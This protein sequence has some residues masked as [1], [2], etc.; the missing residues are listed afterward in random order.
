MASSTLNKSHLKFTSA[1]GHAGQLSF[2]DSGFAVNKSLTLHSD[3]TSNLEA[4]TKEYVDA[5]V[6]GLSVKQPVRVATVTGVQYSYMS[7][8]TH[9]KEI[10]GIIVETGDRLLI[11]EGDGLDPGV[12]EIQASGPPKKLITSGGFTVEMIA[13]G[14]Y[15]YIEEGTVNGGTAYVVVTTN[16]TTQNPAVW[17]IFSRRDTP[18]LV[19]NLLDGSTAGSVVNSKAVIYGSSGEVHAKTLKIDGTPI[20]AT[21]SELNIL[22][23]VTATAE[24]L[25][26]V[27]GSTAGSVVNSKAVIYGSSGEVHAKTLKIDGTPINATAS[28]LNILHG[29]TVTAADLNRLD[30]A[31]AG[32]HT[33][34]KAAIYGEHG[35]LTAHEFVATSDGRL[36]T[37]AV[38][39][40]DAVAKVKQIR[41]VDFNWK[42]T[43]RPDTGVIAQEVEAVMPNAVSGT[44]DET[45]SVAY[46]KLT[47]LLIQAVKEQQ[48]Q[49]DE[50]KALIESKAD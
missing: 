27:D 38:E 37:N 5:K 18:A 11:K 19:R 16:I 20:N 41:G 25:N 36:K 10:D 3:P 32:A 8:F 49:I 26:L 50:L 39:I 46:G 47:A 13:T 24:E 28:E 12:Y 31:A 42:D 40:S 30:G 4:A 6:Q 35:K 22:D 48:Q 34:N 1:Q 7:G 45:R 33:S 44:G 29:A 43:G 14:D 9:G 17:A 2:D 15:V 21:A 23:G